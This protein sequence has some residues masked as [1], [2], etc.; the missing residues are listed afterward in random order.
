M[1]KP[2]VIIPSIRTIEPRHIAAIPEEVRSRV[3]GLGCPP[4]YRTY[5]VETFE[6]LQRWG[7]L[8]AGDRGWEDADDVKGQAVAG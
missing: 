4:L 2:V 5:F 3:R 1:K 6:R 8:F 7:G